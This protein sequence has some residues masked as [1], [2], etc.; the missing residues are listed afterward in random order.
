M[1]KRFLSLM[2]V[3]SVIASLIVAIPMT[4]N[5]ATTAYTLTYEEEYSRFK[6]V[7]NTQATVGRISLRFENA[8]A[9]VRL[10]LHFFY[11]F[12]HFVKCDFCGFF[13]AFNL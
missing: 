6:V 2:M 13:V 8:K 4:A 10:L 7:I 9:V 12:F 11:K 5:A 1:K 3:L